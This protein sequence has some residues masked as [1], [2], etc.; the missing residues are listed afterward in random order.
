MAAGMNGF[1]DVFSKLALIFQP[2][3]D[4]YLKMGRYYQH[5]PWRVPAVTA[6][7]RA[8]DKHVFCTDG[9]DRFALQAFTATTRVPTFLALKTPTSEPSTSTRMRTMETAVQQ[10][11]RSSRG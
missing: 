11:E 9:R 6:H 2:Q 7:S 10:H 1:T 8:Y 3:A 5:V 4:F